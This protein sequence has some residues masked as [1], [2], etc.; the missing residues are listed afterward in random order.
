MTS[1]SWSVEN[2]IVEFSFCLHNFLAYIVRK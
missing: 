1:V 2:W